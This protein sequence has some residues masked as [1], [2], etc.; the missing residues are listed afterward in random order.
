MTTPLGEWGLALL[1]VAG[2]ASMLFIGVVPAV[3]WLA[4]YRLRRA[5]M[6]QRRPLVIRSATLVSARS[7]VELGQTTHWA[8][9]VFP[10][11]PSQEFQ[12]PARI[13]A[14]PP[15]TLGMLS[16]CGPRFERFEDLA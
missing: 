9:F 13:A 1:V 7:G 10:D 8:T 3:L 12:V 5:G 11:A 16:S 15:G 14:L 2:L 6:E 4:W